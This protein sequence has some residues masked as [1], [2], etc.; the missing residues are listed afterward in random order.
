MHSTSAN[1]RVLPPGAQRKKKIMKIFSIN[2]SKANAYLTPIFAPTIGVAIRMFQ[3]AANQDG[4]DFNIYAADYTLF[5]IGEW[6]EETG[7]LKANEVNKNIIN[8]LDVKDQ[9]IQ[10]G[11]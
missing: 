2:D 3:K 5:E 8:G 9:T 6:N 4:S 1:P 11:E 7:R 10:G